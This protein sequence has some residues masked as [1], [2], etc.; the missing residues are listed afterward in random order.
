MM[1]K[2]LVDIVSQIPTPL[3]ESV[4]GI[5]LHSFPD[6]LKGSITMAV[7]IEGAIGVSLLDYAELR[8]EGV[9]VGGW[10][11]LPDMVFELPSDADVK[12]EIIALNTSRILG[13]TNACR[14]DTQDVNARL[15][16]GYP[17]YI[18]KPNRLKSLSLYENG[19]VTYS[20]SEL[21][22]T[23]IKTGTLDEVEI[24]LLRDAIQQYEHILSLGTTEG[25]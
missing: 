24:L 8:S 19:K 11:G 4:H 6:A 3:R 22:T 15:V 7:H 21:G 23:G 20:L 13:T 5:S 25:D 16:Y 18:I 14:F 9:T 10:G 2:Q 1:H 12:R 17:S